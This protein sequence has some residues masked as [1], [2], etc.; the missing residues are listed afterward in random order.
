VALTL[1][2]LSRRLPGL[3]FSR[4]VV[5]SMRS[6]ERITPAPVIRED[7]HGAAALNSISA[8][9]TSRSSCR[10][11]RMKEGG[12]LEQRLL[13][14]ASARRDRENTPRCLARGAL[15]CQ[16]HSRSNCNA[17]HQQC[18]LAGG[19]QPPSPREC[20]TI[21]RPSKFAAPSLRRWVTGSGQVRKFP[22]GRRACAS[23][24]RFFAPRSASLPNFRPEKEC[25]R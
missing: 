8:L 11:S 1:R 21:P 10:A 4:L 18:E 25:G 17:L 12:T 5:R 6:A 19:H 2:H 13:P 14:E 16:A 20:S 23:L 3:C 24:T 9:M 15:P 22:R 7:F